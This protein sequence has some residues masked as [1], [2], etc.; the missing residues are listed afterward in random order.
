ML[1]MKGLS[2]TFSG[3]VLAAGII[4][5]PASL[6]A[7]PVERTK[8][9]TDAVLSVPSPLAEKLKSKLAELKSKLTS[10]NHQ[11]QENAYHAMVLSAMGEHPLV[12]Q[13]LGELYV[14]FDTS[15]EL[16][17]SASK[18]GAQENLAYEKYLEKS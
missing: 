3:L 11:V 13:S 9:D 15:A 14:M 17:E 18:G 8:Q 16:L 6:A 5:H 7:E 2:S 1:S 12:K 4:V 10:I